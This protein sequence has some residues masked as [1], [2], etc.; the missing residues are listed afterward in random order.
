MKRFF[1]LIVLV[2]MV[3]WLIASH[4]SPSRRLA[5]ANESLGGYRAPQS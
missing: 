5:A 3:S 2:V 4:R 1:L